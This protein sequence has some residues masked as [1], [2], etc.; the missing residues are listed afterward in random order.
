ME[1]TRHNILGGTFKQK[2]LCDCDYN[3]D[4]IRRMLMQFILLRLKKSELILC[5]I[6]FTLGIN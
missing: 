4:F 6:Q 2:V 3:I 5:N 1:N